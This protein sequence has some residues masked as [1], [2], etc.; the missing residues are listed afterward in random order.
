LPL[1]DR[2]KLCLVGNCN[3]SPHKEVLNI[4]EAEWEPMIKPDGMAADFRRQ[5]MTFIDRPHPS[6]IA[7][8]G[9]S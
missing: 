6:I 3:T 8:I 7:E 9:L 5:S 4:A 1:A 2:K